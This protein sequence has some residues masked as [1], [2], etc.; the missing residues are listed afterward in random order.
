MNDI[1]V[2]PERGIRDVQR[3]RYIGTAEP[4][5]VGKTALISKCQG[6]WN[7]Q[8]DDRWSGFGFGWWRFDEKDWEVIPSTL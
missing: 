4:K 7:I 8:A 5:L 2:G 1:K 6:G 3:G